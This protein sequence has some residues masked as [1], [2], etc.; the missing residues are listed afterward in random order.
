[1]KRHSQALKCFFVALSAGLLLSSAPASADIPAGYTGTPFKGTPWPIPGRIDLVNYDMGGLNVGFNTVLHGDV[2][3]A[4]FDYR[5]DL[6]V[7]TLCKT[8]VMEGDHFSAGPLLGTT[9][10]SP[11]TADY[12]VGAIR[13]GDWVKVTVNVKTAGTYKLSSDWASAGGSID[14]Q[15]Y[16]NDVLKN[17]TKL[18]S[19]GGYHNWV[20][21]PNYAMVQLDQGVQV[22]KFQSPVEH[23][24]FDYVQFSLVLPD[25]GV[26]NGGRGSR[27]SRTPRR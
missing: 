12:Y 11:T 14:M 7:A 15:I 13:P 2:G 8:S 3:C 23:L 17:E 10:P 4:G 18:P 16:F 27:S 24:N 26:D 22:M 19:T 25:G 20:P 6:P 21:Y 5:M 9:Y 1:M